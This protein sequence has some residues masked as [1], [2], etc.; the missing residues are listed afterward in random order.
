[1]AHCLAA[2]LLLGVPVS[3]LWAA[4]PKT[5]EVRF[6]THDGHE[7]FGKLT[8]PA[9]EGPHAVVIYV[10]TAEAMTVDLKRPSQGAQTFSIQS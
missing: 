10:Q 3:A 2:G 7:M 1:M 9:S 5:S 4:D 8:L 6:T